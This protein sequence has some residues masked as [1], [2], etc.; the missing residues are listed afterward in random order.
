MAAR[1][2][3]HRKDS[4]WGKQAPISRRGFAQSQAGN[5]PCFPVDQA[6]TDPA[7]VRFAT[8]VGIRDLWSSNWDQ[9]GATDAQPE[10]EP[11]PDR[12]TSLA[13]SRPTDLVSLHFLRLKSVYINA[14]MLILLR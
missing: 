14:M 8:L 9:R 2:L 11:Q 3:S 5:H 4:Y 1:C 7:E 12:T 13:L 6:H 10:L